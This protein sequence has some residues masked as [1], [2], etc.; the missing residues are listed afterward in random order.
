MP[1]NATP[2]QMQFLRQLGYKDSAKLT[3]QQASQLIERMLAE[4]KASGKTFPCPYCKAKFGPRPKRE[5]K[6][7]SCGNTI[8][9]LSGKFY[10]QAEADS[11][12]QKDWLKESR[13]YAKSQVREEWKEERKFRKEFGE[14]L[15]VGYSITAG[16]QCPHTKRLEGLLVLIEDAYDSTDLLPP[17]DSCKHDT[18]ECE[19]IAVMH[20]EVKKG[21]RIAEFSDPSVQA[22]LTTRK[23][24]PVGIQNRKS[25]SG[26]ASILLL[27]LLAVSAVCYLV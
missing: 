24:S 4:E 7:P 3:K 9:Q 27:L 22:K 11:K 15:I 25:K 20:G 12:Y 6:C 23:T 2:R 1:D 19:F 26:C 8:V 21:T 10:T 17:F 18:C 5:K 16:P 13:Q 14:P